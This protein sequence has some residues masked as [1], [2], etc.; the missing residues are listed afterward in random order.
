MKTNDDKMDG[1]IVWLNDSFFMK[2]LT[3]FTGFVVRLLYLNCLK[4]KFPM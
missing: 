4:T 2:V 3:V 1:K